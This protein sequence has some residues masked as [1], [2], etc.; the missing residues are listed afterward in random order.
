MNNANGTFIEKERITE[1]IIRLYEYGSSVYRTRTINSDR[2]YIVVVKSEEKFSYNVRNEDSD[3]TVYS[4]PLFIDM[5][6][7]HDVHILE[8]IFQSED[9]RYLIHFDLDLEKLRRKFSAVASNSYV[10]CK[11]KIRDGEVYIGLKS[12]F[13]SLR[14]LDFAIQIAKHG[15]I[16]N[17]SSVNVLLG[18]IMSTK[19][20]WKVLD[21]MFKP[22]YNSLKSELRV[23]AP[24]KSELE[25]KEEL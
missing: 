23:L 7:E 6:K 13:H 11:K 18:V 5:I 20:D 17:Y 9:D 3:Y 4:E 1:P 8:C 14:I 12:L 22:I 19:P 10:K 2:D 21:P 24:L 16:V 15:R 25:T